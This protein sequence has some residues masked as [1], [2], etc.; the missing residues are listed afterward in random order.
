MQ[1]AKVTIENV[2][3]RWREIASLN[4]VATPILPD[5]VMRQGCHARPRQG[6]GNAAL[7]VGP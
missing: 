1:I 5:I 7:P 3:S 2:L 6:S 4:D